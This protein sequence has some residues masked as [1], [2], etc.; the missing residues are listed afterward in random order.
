MIFK[1]DNECKYYP[2]TEDSEASFLALGLLGASDACI[3]LDMAT[4]VED[5]HLQANAPKWTL[6]SLTC[7]PTHP[8]TEIG[9][10]S[11]FLLTCRKVILLDYQAKAFGIILDTLLLTPPVQSVGRFYLL[12][13]RITPSLCPPLPSLPP[14][15]W[16]S[17][18]DAVSHSSVDEVSICPGDFLTQKVVF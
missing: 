2:F 8:P 9:S 17:L 5:R 16:T 6:E 10:S 4:W 1:W 14:P 15:A 18:M 13:F 11:L 3:L 7:L 12:V